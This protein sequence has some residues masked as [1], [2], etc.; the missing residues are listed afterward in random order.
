MRPGSRRHVPRASPKAADA[1]RWIRDLLRADLHRGGYP[2]GKL[3]AEDILMETNRASRAVVRHAL[4]VLRAEG[5]IERIQGIGTIAL[6]SL[7]S[8]SLEE[9]Q[10]LIAP[11]DSGPFAGRSRPDI[12]DH[13]EIVLPRLVAERLHVPPG[14]RGV[15]IDYVSYYAGQPSWIATNYMRL[16]EATALDADKFRTD[17]YAYLADCGLTTKETTYLMEATLADELDASLLSIS[18]GS[19]VMAGEQVLFN[20]AGE[21][22]NFALVRLR[23]DRIAIMT[24][25]TRPPMMASEPG[26]SSADRARE[27]AEQA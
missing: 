5:L 3:P 13:S 18:A 4:E 2:S 10:G 25:A 20:E 21:P 1:S 24:K 27:T 22:Y 26:E 23:G 15:R 17:F 16:P 9:A 19:A 14:S 12:L 8:L 11:R 7:D 6:S